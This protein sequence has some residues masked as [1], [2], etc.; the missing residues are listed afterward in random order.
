MKVI[1]WQDVPRKRVPSRSQVM[2]IASFRK[3]VADLAAL[4]QEGALTFTFLDSDL[5]GMSFKEPL[6]GNAIKAA[7]RTLGKKG[8]GYR[9]EV[10]GTT[11]YAG[12]TAEQIAAKG[13]VDRTLD[14]HPSVQRA[15]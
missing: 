8:L 15:S 3:F 7:I 4:K 14:E 6:E 12:K 5:K 2:E 10:R 13:R 11:I 1:K 9:V